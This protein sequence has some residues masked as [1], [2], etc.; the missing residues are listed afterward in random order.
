MLPSSIL[1]K[2]ILE[3]AMIKGHGS[4]DDRLNPNILHQQ[5]LYL[6]SELNKYKS[7]VRDYQEDYHYS[8]LEKLKIENSQ[9]LREQ[10]QFTS[11]IE[12]MN[13][14]NLTLQN[15]IMEKET[16][17]ERLKQ[18]IEHLKEEKS[19]VSNRLEQ[20]ESENKENT[21]EFETYSRTNQQL[22]SQVSSLENELVL[23]SDQQTQSEKMIQKLQDSNQIL[24]IQN[25]QLT[26]ETLSYKEEIK[27]MAGQVNQ[28]Q[29]LITTQNQKLVEHND[30]QWK[31]KSEI[32]TLQEINEGLKEEKLTLESFQNEMFDKIEDLKREMLS[33]SSGEITSS[34][35]QYTKIEYS[36]LYQQVEHIFSQINE[37]GEKISTCVS[38]TNHLEKH[39]DHLTDEI[40]QLKSALIVG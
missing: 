33:Y 6:N 25:K 39:I 11:Q 31:N 4:S 21:K 32:Q 30:L 1:K 29:N 7:K 18:Q 15:R 12:E 8:Q 5:I 20:V 37:Y 19:V 2:T 34:L 16:L 27:K 13:H 10:Q 14:K 35:P 3:V 26:G 22:Q 9:L 36:K 40:N 38:L 28:L 17:V 24:S 23:R